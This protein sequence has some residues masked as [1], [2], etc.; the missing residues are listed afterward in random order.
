MYDVSEDKLIEKNNC[1]ERT[2]VYRLAY[3][4]TRIYDLVAFKVQQIVKAYSDGGQNG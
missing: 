2:V 4:F 1:N 3:F